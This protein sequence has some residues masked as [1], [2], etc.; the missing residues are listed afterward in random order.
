MKH[1]QRT[2]PRALWQR[3]RAHPVWLGILAI[4]LLVL[5]SLCL[6]L[7]RPVQNFE[8]SGNDLWGLQDQLPVARGEDGT[9]SLQPGYEEA[10]QK[11]QEAVTDENNIG[12]GLFGTGWM[13]IYR[14]RYLFTV[15]YTVPRP[16][17]AET[18][19]GTLRANISNVEAAGYD[20]TMT[21]DQTTVSGHFWI[22]GRKGEMT[23]QV[24]AQDPGLAVSRVTVQEDWFWRVVRLVTALVL[25]VL[26]DLLVYALTPGNRWLTDERDRAVLFGLLAVTLLVGY[27]TFSD[28][29]GHGPDTYYHYNRIWSIA[30]GLRSGQFPVRI[31]PD[32]LNGYGYASP[33][34]YGETLLYFPALLVL[35][36][37]P[38]YRALNALLFVTGALTV[39]IGWISFYKMF[40]SRPAAFTATALYATASYRLTDCYWRHGVGEAIAIAFLP[41]LAWGFWALYADDAPQKEHDRAW[42]PLM[43]GFTG[44][45]QSHTVSTEIMAFTA[46]ALVLLCVRRAFRPS[47]LLILLKGAG[48]TVLVN[49]WFVVPFLQ[50][51]ISDPYRG[52]VLENRNLNE[53]RT[54]VGFLFRLWDD[55]LSTQALRIGG[56]LVVGAA[57]YLFC[58]AVFPQK[59]RRANQIGTAAAILGG[60]GTYLVCALDWNGLYDL[61]GETIAKTL[62]NIQFPFRY[63]M[64]VSLCFAL[65]AGCGVLILAQAGGKKAGGAAAAGLV[66]F[67]CLLAWMDC[68]MYAHGYIGRNRTAEG[69][70]IQSGKENSMLEYLPVGFDEAWTDDTSIQCMNG[71]EVSA[72]TREPLCFTVTAQNPTGG[73]ASVELPLIYYPGYRLTA[74]DGG[75]V[76]VAKTAGGK[77]AVILS[78]GYSG[79]FTVRFVAPKLWR[80]CELVSAA[81]VLWLIFQPFLKKRLRRKNV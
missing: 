27:P 59:N 68:G 76:S 35:A 61:L 41:L 9:V 60:I 43:L 48:L 31:Y 4:E 36:G 74:N 24:Y 19:A 29:S 8:F 65:M 53:N 62:C 47:N 26:A 70:D 1:R 75:T 78:P 72:G 14:G 46:V 2:T 5:L 21:A 50:Y 11:A 20:L 51:Y 58:R 33:I 28:F 30:Q 66:V 57:L 71:A 52:T 18:V 39:A 13:D 55:D 17:T 49:L 25:F 69:R 40:G 16:G 79:T 64:P 54:S 3:L 12:V 7:A 81:T 56:A 6:A 22:Q 38:L 37:F 80:L 32:F 23:L 63:L 34:F 42:L 10:F 77:V 44:L 73:D 45:I 67:A 15:S